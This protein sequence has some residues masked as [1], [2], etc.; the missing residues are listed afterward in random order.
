MRI[1][2]DFWLISLVLSVECTFI[3]LDPRPPKIH[4]NSWTPSRSITPPYIAVMSLLI[5]VM[6]SDKF[7]PDSPPPP[8]PPSSP[9]ESYCLIGMAGDVNLFLNDPE[10][11]HT[12]EIEVIPFSVELSQRW[13]ANYPQ[14]IQSLAEVNL[15]FIIS[16]P[17]QWNSPHTCDWSWTSV[18]L[19]RPRW[20]AEA[21]Y[22]CVLMDDAF[23]LA[24]RS[25]FPLKSI[26]WR[27]AHTVMLLAGDGC[28]PQI[29]RKG[30]SLRGLNSPH[31]VCHNKFG[32][33]MCN[34]S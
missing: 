9:I 22:A 7:C 31:V 34:T 26:I 8:P 30:A 4:C 21:D 27:K 13:T 1:W 17:Y 12:A 10:D 32:E 33:A 11:R 25:R 19:G 18:W 20:R 6:F 15:L 29:K 3:L 16:T 23:Y 2:A 28:Q 14:E 5:E 24:L